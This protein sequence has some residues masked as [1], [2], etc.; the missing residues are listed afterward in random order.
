[1]M[2][3]Q[4]ENLGAVLIDRPVIE[5]H[6]NEKGKNALKVYSTGSRRCEDV[7][8]LVLEETNLGKIPH[9]FM[10][11]DSPYWTEHTAT[12][13]VRYFTINQSELKS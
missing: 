1:M 4:L 11:G 3:E 9:I 5:L 10:N 8:D 2:K 13:V 12:P 6:V 7:I